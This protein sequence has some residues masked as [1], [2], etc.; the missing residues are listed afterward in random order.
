VTCP[1]HGAKFDI[2]TGEVL[3]DPAYDAVERHN[4]RISG[5]DIEVEI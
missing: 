1:W 3:Q 4:A 2:R 5:T